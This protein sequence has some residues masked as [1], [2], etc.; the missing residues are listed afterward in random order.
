MSGSGGLLEDF[1]GLES[2]SRNGMRFARQM[3]RGA[4]GN[5]FTITGS[6]ARPAE[7]GW[8]EGLEK[9]YRLRSTI[10]QAAGACALK[11]RWS[12]GPADSWPSAPRSLLPK[13]VAISPEG[14]AAPAGSA[15]RSEFRSQ[16]DAF[17]ASGSCLYFSSRFLR[18]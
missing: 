4:A 6:G 13:P 14:S 16:V 1:L 18:V 12:H 10:F 8:L 11:S 3:P 7:N 2:R 5:R 17:E 15:E 9:R